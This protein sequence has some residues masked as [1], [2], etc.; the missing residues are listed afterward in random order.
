MFN[1]GS[2]RLC[3]TD[4]NGLLQ[5]FS[6]RKPSKIKRKITLTVV[7]LTNDLMLDWSCWYVCPQPQNS[8]KIP[9]KTAVHNAAE[10][11]LFRS[12]HNLKQLF[13]HPSILCNE[14]ITRPVFHVSVKV[15]RYKVSLS[16]FLS[17]AGVPPLM[18][19][20]IINDSKRGVDSTQPCLRVV[21]SGGF[22]DFGDGTCCRHGKFP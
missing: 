12:K 4:I 13:S 2:Q 18:A 3:R 11:D 16:V 9:K 20:V 17:L 21:R 22:N 14:N 8:P 7:L 6:N 10:K 5:Y 19:S 15:M 1:A